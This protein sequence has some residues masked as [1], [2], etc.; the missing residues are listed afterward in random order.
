[1]RM[2]VTY[3]RVGSVQSREYTMPVDSR[4]PRSR[5]NHLGFTTRWKN[6]KYLSRVYFKWL[7]V[8][9][10][11]LLLLLRT[12]SGE[13]AP[14]LRWILERMCRKADQVSDHLW[15]MFKDDRIP[16]LSD[17]LT[18]LETASRYFSSV[19]ITIDAI[20][21]SNPRRE[22]LK[23]LRDLATDFR[24]S[25][26]RLL[27]TSREYMD[28]EKVMEE[29]STEV[30]IR[31]AY[32]DADFR[33]YTE[34]RLAT[35]DKLKD[36]TEDLR[37]EALEAISCGAK[38]M[39]RWVV[40]Q[41]D[42]LRRLNGNKA[43]I[44]N[45]LKNLP[46]TL[47]ETYD[48]IFDIIPEEDRQVVA[49]ALDWICFHYKLFRGPSIHVGCKLLLEAIKGD[50]NRQNLSIRDYRYDVEFFRESCGCLITVTLDGDNI[51]DG[52][53]KFVVSFSHYTVMEYLAI[54]TRFSAESS[55]YLD[56]LTAI[57]GRTSVIF[58]EAFQ[59]D[60][61]SETS[62]PESDRFSPG[63]TWQWD[64]GTYC[65]FA[66][67]KMMVEYEEVILQNEELATMVTTPHHSRTHPLD[68]IRRLY[69]LDNGV[70]NVEALI[71]RL[72][73]AAIEWCLDIAIE[74]HVPLSPQTWHSGRPGLHGSF[75]TR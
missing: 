61:A 22:L 55:F 5:Q 44:R 17:L 2:D 6:R 45:E 36:W 56:K 39:F 21:E 12:Q 41:L 32:L 34:S 42:A 11:S 10:N 18:A 4:D 35:N 1:M 49:S 47:N 54:S 27:V 37:N 20:D 68:T 57:G 26:I 33:Q 40:C 73:L 69:L 48:R 74:F 7:C 23:V 30:S 14:F 75:Q 50:L 29:I 19:C 9:W 66:A 51:F 62:T 8:D 60:V 63:I 43:A 64:F 16:S 24:F 13:A 70:Y 65:S 72:G 58:S 53:E 28:I 38:G 3:S 46:K 15:R 71:E 59:Y 31:N 25:N 67:L 52:H